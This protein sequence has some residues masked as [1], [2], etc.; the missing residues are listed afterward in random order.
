[1][2]LEAGEEL[3]KMPDLTRRL[4][5]EELTPGR[6]VDLLPQSGNVACMATRAA[7][8]TIVGTPCKCPEGMVYKTSNRKNAKSYT[9][10]RA[11]K[12]SYIVR[13]EKVYA[14][15][16]IVPKYKWRRTDKAVT[17]RDIFQFVMIL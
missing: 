12:G 16:L 9:K 1:M 10:M 2:S 5:P 7:T 6:K 11:G 17:L 14:P 8:A 3:D 4:T 15:A 13:I